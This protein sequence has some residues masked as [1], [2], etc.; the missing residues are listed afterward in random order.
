MFRVVGVV[1]STDGAVDVGLLVDA[2][3]DGM[4]NLSSSLLIRKCCLW[5]KGRK[6]LL[7]QGLHCL[8]F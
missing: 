1:G 5:E 2:V 6:L 4:L 3:A 7:W 8:E